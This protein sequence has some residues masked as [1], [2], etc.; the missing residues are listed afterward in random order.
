MRQA[1]LLSHNLRVAASGDGTPREY[2]PQ[3][4]HLLLLGTADG[5]AIGAKGPFSA[6]GR[7]LWHLKDL[8]DRRFVQRYR[9][10]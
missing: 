6:E 8:I 10:R 5:S 9:L 3:R 4:Q 7:C 2:R 1:P